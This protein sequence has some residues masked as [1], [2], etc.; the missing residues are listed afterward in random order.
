MDSEQ[1]ASVRIFESVSQERDL[2][3]QAQH[4]CEAVLLSQGEVE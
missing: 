2:V 1:R 3:R 4:L